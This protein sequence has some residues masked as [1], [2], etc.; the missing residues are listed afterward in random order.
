MAEA[1][2]WL[3]PAELLRIVQISSAGTSLIVDVADGY[4]ADT[5][6]R[7]EGVVRRR[8]RDQLEVAWTRHD[9]NDTDGT[10]VTDFPAAGFVYPEVTVVTDSADGKTRRRFLGGH[11]TPTVGPAAISATA[12]TLSSRRS[13][14]TRPA[15]FAAAVDVSDAVNGLKAS[16]QRIAAELRA[17]ARQLEERVSARNA[18]G[19]EVVTALQTQLAAFAEANKKLRSTVAELTARVVQL[20]GSRHRED[21]RVS[22]TCESVE[23]IRRRLASTEDALAQLRAEIAA[24]P[25]STSPVQHD[26]AD[27]DDNVSTRSGGSLRLVGSQVQLFDASTWDTDEFA[28]DIVLARLERKMLAD[29]AKRCPRS[30][31]CQTQLAA[32]IAELRTVIASYAHQAWTADDVVV[33][34][35]NRLLWSLTATVDHHAGLRDF[36]AVM[37]RFDALHPDKRE[38]PAA[39][40]AEVRDVPR[41]SAT[42][43]EATQRASPAKPRPKTQGGDKPGAGASL[44]Q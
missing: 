13:S 5:I 36:S 6:L 23:S 28:I 8:L 10:V 14:P 37:A 11:P 20:E 17:S 41:P 19:N 31:S 43:R 35:L 9:G 2:A 12:S 18:T 15:N 1:R 40:A 44:K 22:E 4:N 29:A 39:Y 42:S 32:T 27:A 21:P 34:R 38:A 30:T 33:V 24:R 3:T 26:P 16:I 25:S 7:W